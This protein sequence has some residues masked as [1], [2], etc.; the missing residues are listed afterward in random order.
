MD[1][2][3]KVI[4]GGQ[5]LEVT[6]ASDGIAPAAAVVVV[7]TGTT[8]LGGGKVRD[9][10][11]HYCSLCDKDFHSDFNLKRHMR[12]FHSENGAAPPSLFHCE[13]CKKNF[14]NR[15]NLRRHQSA[16]HGDSGESFYCDICCTDFQYRDNL[17]RHMKDVHKQEFP[18]QTQQVQ[19][20]Q[21]QQLQQ[22][23]PQQQHQ[24]SVQT[25]TEVVKVRTEDFMRN[26]CDF[27]RPN[28]PSSN[29]VI[30]LIDS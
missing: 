29:L 30:P 17:R 25:T 12:D 1:F 21:Q 16:V 28:R 22:Q 8:P 26:I 11:P 27:F 24:Q 18:R 19:Q 7:P 6:P 15:F 10:T 2:L 20:Q 9:A 14:Q 13:I 23:Q 3:P 4:R 5:I